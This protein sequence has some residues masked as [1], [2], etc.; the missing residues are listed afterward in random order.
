MFFKNTH[1][2]FHEIYFKDDDKVEIFDDER[3]ADKFNEFY[4][5]VGKTLADKIGPSNK[6]FESYVIENRQEMGEKDLT[7]EELED[8][9]KSLESNKGEGLDE[10]HV[11]IVKS[12][13]DLIKD[14]LHFIFNLSLKQGIFPNELKLARVIPVFKSGDDSLVSNYR[15]ISILPCLSKILERIMYNRLYSFLLEHNLLYQKQ[16]GFQNGHSTEH[17]VI[18]LVDEIVKGFDQDMFTLGVFID[19]SKA[20]DTVNHKILLKKLELYGVKN[21]NLKWFANYLSERKQGVSFRSN[22]SQ[23]KKTSSVESHKDQFLGHY[24]FLYM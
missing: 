17:A 9:F 21:N 7:H 23:L 12:V 19:L 22:V 14:P 13:F 20:F 11:N 8:A 4:V 24:F 10:I 5:N 1:F 15:P 6:T 3:I 18:K 2:D 16:F